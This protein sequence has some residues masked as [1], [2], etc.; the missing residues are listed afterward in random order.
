[1]T[2]RDFHHKTG[3]RGDGALKNLEGKSGIRLLIDLL[4]RRYSIDTI[5]YNDIEA[6][7]QPL[8]QEIAEDYPGWLRHSCY[9]F[10][11]ISLCQWGIDS[12]LEV[13]IPFS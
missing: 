11:G 4:R 10:M 8:P 6:D 5:Y 13:V 12:I 7:Y 9:T 3:L 1:M 2:P